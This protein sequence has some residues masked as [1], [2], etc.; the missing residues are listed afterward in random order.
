MLVAIG[1][2]IIS[3]VIRLQLPLRIYALLSVAE[4]SIIR[5]WLVTRVIESK[6]SSIR[7]IAIWSVGILIHQIVQCVT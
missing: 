1:V 7:H 3:V 5:V 4:L 2:V 6:S